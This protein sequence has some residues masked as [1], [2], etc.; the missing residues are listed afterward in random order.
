MSEQLFISDLHLSAAT[1]D[2][3]SL[4]V[5]FLDHRARS[6]SHL[7]ILG[8]LFD[9][10]VGDDDQQPPIPQITQALRRL[11]DSGV[12]LLLMHG[13]RDFMIGEDFCTQ[14]GAQLLQDPSLVDLYGTPTLLMHGDLLCTD[15]LAYQQFR[16]QIRTAEM[17]N[18]FR[19]LPIEQRFELARQFRA[20]SGEANATKADDIMDVND[21]AVEDYIRRYDAQRLIHGH[22]HRPADHIHRVSGQEIT[23]HVLAEWHDQSAEALVVTEQGLCRESL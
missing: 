5:N 16:K 19:S 3:C 21:G 14:T 13:N 2:R 8:D 20:Q 12:A 1:G 15:D 23:R 18:H 7:Y 11:T 10:W 4:F 17:I 6:A 22:T 9:A